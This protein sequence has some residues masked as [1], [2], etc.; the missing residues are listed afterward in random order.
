MAEEAMEA[1]MVAERAGVLLEA[2]VEMVER[3]SHLRIR[4]RHRQGRA[5]PICVWG[6]EGVEV[7]VRLRKGF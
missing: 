4:S 3:E 5:Q 6:V 1:A 2:L 7:H